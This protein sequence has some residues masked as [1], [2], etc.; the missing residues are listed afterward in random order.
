[1][2][3]QGTTTRIE[4]VT[5]PL[6]GLLHV[7]SEDG[8]AT[9]REVARRI[10]GENVSQPQVGVTTKQLHKLR[11]LLYVRTQGDFYTTTY[12]GN[13]IETE[14]IKD[15][16]HRFMDG[17]WEGFLNIVSKMK[18]TD[19]EPSIQTTPRQKHRVTPAQYKV[20]RILLRANKELSIRNISE[21]MYGEELGRY[22]TSNI[23]SPII[24]LRRK[25]LVKVGQ[26]GYKLATRFEKI[27]EMMVLDLVDKVFY[28]SWGDFKTAVKKVNW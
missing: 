17:D 14:A 1:M 21:R 5:H 27:Q 7:L 12:S 4:R 18:E 19:K 6:F 2:R 22:N 23:H 26:W 3:L 9:S 24:A 15:F 16:V 28:S 20:A 25:G 11:E 10:Y 13:H 8:K